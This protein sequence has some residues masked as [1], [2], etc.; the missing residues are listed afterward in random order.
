MKLV[1]QIPCFNEEQTLPQTIRDLPKSIPGIDVI[2]ILVVDDGSTDRTVEVARSCGVRHIL[3]LGTNRGLG[4]AFSKGLE[5]AVLLGADVVVNTDADNQYVGADVAKLVEPILQHHADM[6]VGCRPIIS[7]PEFSPLKKTLQLL[8]SWTLRLLSKTSVRDAAS[9]FRA[10][11]REAC[12]R[13]VIYSRFSYCMESLIQAGNSQLR[14]DSVDIRVNSTTRQS[15]LFK[16]TPEYLWKSGATMVTMFVHYRPSL[17]FGLL[18]AVNLAGAVFLG[19]RFL[20]L[21]YLTPG[22]AAHRTYIPSLILLAVLTIFGVGCVTLAIIAELQRV[23]R[24]LVEEALYQLRRQAVERSSSMPASSQNEHP[25]EK[26]RAA[27]QDNPR[28]Q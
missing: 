12:L 21:V 22:A 28:F 5:K 26:A 18:S 11:S 4:R 2:E 20:Y 10:F 13:L 15:R 25:A 7:H 8:G 6:V 1:I 16:S 27:I 19:L 9:G 14:V 24:R 23:N 3:S 17:F